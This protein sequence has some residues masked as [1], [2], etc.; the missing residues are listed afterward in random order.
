MRMR[1]P[2]LTVAFA[3]ALPIAACNREGAPP[4]APVESTSDTSDAG[5]PAALFISAPPPVGR[6]RCTA[7]IS[8]GVIKT[9]ANCTLDERISKGNGTLLYPCSGE[10]PVEAVFAEHRFEGRLSE[11]SIT[12]ALTTELDWEDGCHWETKQTM[13]GDW[14]RDAK[15][16]KLS[17]SYSERPVTGSSCFG[18]C[19]ARADVEVDELSQ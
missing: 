15:K 1:A 7:R 3:C 5:P 4:V 10:G 9:G 6:D 16:Q 14:K 11:G 2:A 18:Q 8:A 17:W 12:L 19:V 13:R